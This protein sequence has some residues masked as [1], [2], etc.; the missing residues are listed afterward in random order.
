MSPT[1]M[2]SVMTYV[3]CMPSSQ[4]AISSYHNV[5]S[6]SSQLLKLHSPILPSLNSCQQK[7][8]QKCKEFYDQKQE[9]LIEIQSLTQSKLTLIGSL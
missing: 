2:S 1:G 3:G 8:E 5:W 9:F 4:H 6:E 7:L